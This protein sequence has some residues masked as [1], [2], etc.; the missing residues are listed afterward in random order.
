MIHLI[1]CLRHAAQ[2]LTLRD[3]PGSLESAPLLFALEVLCVLA[4]AGLAA[5]GFISS[6]DVRGFFG[7]CEW[8]EDC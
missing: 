7:E 3:M 5:A 4:G 8:I 6:K 2:A 1:F